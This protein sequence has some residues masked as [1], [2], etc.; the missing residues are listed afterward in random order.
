MVH[1]KIKARLFINY[2]QIDSYNRK[3]KSNRLKFSQMLSYHRIHCTIG[4]Q[5]TN[6]RM[7]NN[8]KISSIY[9]YFHTNN[10]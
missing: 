10:S 2:F 5:E 3:L 9:R 4:I 7:E 8:E 6:Q 1:G